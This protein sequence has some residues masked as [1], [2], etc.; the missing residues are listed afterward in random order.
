MVVLLG[1]GLWAFGFE[2]ASWRLRTYRLVLPNWP[3]LYH[4]LRLALLADLHTGSPFNGLAKLRRLVAH[5]NAARPDLVLIAGDL[6]IQGV[7]GGRFVPP[8]PIA[9]V[10]K[11]LQAPLGVYAVL[12]NHDWWFDAARVQQALVDAGIPVLEDHARAITH[13][14]CTFWLVGVSDLWEGPHNLAA[15]L[16]GVTDAAPV[17][18]LTHNPDLFPN[19]PSRVSLTMAGHTHGGQV[20]MPFIGRPLVP[21]RYGERFAS[22]HIIE[23]ERHLFVT[24][25]LGT[26][27]LPVRFLVPPEISL[28]ELLSPRTS[29][30]APPAP[31]TAPCRMQP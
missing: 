19:V 7:V 20:Y 15:A 29:E 26:S 13:K 27:I 31:S 11:G 8:E 28:L 3:A 14:R 10:L 12:G 2:P 6:L 18:L 4:G 21:S 17:L 24:P 1:L 25:G 22:G 5:T 16:R 9:Q 23:Q 30:L